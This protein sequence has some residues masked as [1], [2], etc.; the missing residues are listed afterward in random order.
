MIIGLN[1]VSKFEWNAKKLLR[2]SETSCCLDMGK[3]L[4]LFVYTRIEQKVETFLIAS[5]SILN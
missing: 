5:S 4:C 2:V 1:F 3:P